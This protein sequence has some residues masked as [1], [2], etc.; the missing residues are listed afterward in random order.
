MVFSSILRFFFDGVPILRRVG[1]RYGLSIRLCPLAVGQASVP[2]GVLAAPGCGPSAGV[3]VSGFQLYISGAFACVSDV[4]RCFGWLDPV[5]DTAA[6]ITC[7]HRTQLFACS[8]AVRPHFSRAR[9]QAASRSLRTSPL[10]S[11]ISICISIPL[12]FNSLYF[13]LHEYKEFP[14]FLF[15]G[16]TVFI[17]IG[18]F[19][20]HDADDLS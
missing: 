10:L 3:I 16:Q 7:I 5:C 18:F 13:R 14:V 2:P 6:E 19:H 8:S 11:M 17:K 4:H 15:N 20:I 9:R 1:C 12:Y